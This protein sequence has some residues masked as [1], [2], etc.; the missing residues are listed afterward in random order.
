[1]D[2]PAP[3]TDIKRIK[4]LRLLHG[5]SQAA[6]ASAMGLPRETINRI[7]RGMRVL[8]LRQ[9]SHIAIMFATLDLKEPVAPPAK[10]KKSRYDP[11]KYYNFTTLDGKHLNLEELAALP[12]GTH[13]RVQENLKGWQ[14]CVR[15]HGT[16][17][18]DEAVGS[19]E[20]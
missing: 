15:G 2:I 8:T 20:E 11:R 10:P 5:M 17:H 12:P 6:M 7:E 16:R 18:E 13:Y 19:A 9:A 4:Q 14:T 1:M 3:I